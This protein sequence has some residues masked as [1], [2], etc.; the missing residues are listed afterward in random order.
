[1]NRVLDGKVTCRWPCGVKTMRTEYERSS[2]RSYSVFGFAISGVG[3]W[4]L[5]LER[6]YAYLIIRVPCTWGIR[7]RL[8]IHIQLWVRKRPT[9]KSRYHF[10]TSTPTGHV[11]EVEN[12][13]RGRSILWLENGKWKIVAPL[14]QYFPLYNKCSLHN[15]RSLIAMMME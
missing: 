14:H 6:S 2:W 9:P 11:I 1:M 5:L 8:H 13:K 3:Y 10:L 15:T 4:V 7:T 12:G